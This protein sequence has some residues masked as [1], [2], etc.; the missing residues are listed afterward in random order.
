MAIDK[1]DFAQ[2]CVRQGVYFGTNPH[3]ML[4]VA[5]LRSG[6]SDDSAGDQIGPFRLKQADWDANSND[7]DFEIHFQPNQIGSWLRQCAVFALMG[8]RA[9]Q[10]FVAENSRNPSALEL[11]RAQW[12]DASAA[13]VETDLQKALDETAALVGPAADAVLDDPGTAPST[14]PAPTPPPAASP[15]APEADHPTPAPVPTPPPTSPKAP[16]ADHPAPAPAPTPPSPAPAPTPPGLPPIISNVEHREPAPAPIPGK[17]AK[18]R[19]ENQKRWQQVQIHANLVA[20]IDQTAARLVAAPA[21]ARYQ[22]VS[23]RTRV[24]WYIIAVIHEREGS[25]NWRLSIAQGDPWDRVSRNVPAGRGPFSSWEEAALDALIKCAPKAASWPDWSPG[26]A[27]TLLELYNGLG[28]ARKDLPSPYIWA[29]TNQYVRGK[30]VR[31][32]VFDPNVVDQQFG[33]A[34]LLARMKALDSSVQI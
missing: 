6:I 14:V 2:E 28:Y 9:L 7:D 31:D 3:Y 13:S 24:P 32:G 8:H 33:C 12:P 10:T 11:Y 19:G 5:Q 23:A 15:K 21:K 29:S 30:Y 25:Q 4:G 18:L 1:A 22:G 34:A 20:K 17:F 26:G 16:E 27:L